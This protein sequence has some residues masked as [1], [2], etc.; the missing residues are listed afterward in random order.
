[1]AQRRLGFP[2]TA[3]IKWKKEKFKNNLL[4]EN[5]LNLDFS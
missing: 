1:M 5:N 3:L 2:K 4:V